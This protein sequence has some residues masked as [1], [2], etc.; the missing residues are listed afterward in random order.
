MDCRIHIWMLPQLCYVNTS[1]VISPCTAFSIDRSL[2]WIQIQAPLFFWYLNQ[3]PFVF[4][5]FS[6]FLSEDFLRYYTVFSTA[7]TFA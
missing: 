1:R 5:T 4:L 7:T 6:C 2:Y 3:I